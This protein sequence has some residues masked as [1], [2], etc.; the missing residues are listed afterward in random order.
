M[1]GIWTE[2]HFGVM[3]IDIDYLKLRA[4]YG[5]TASLGPATNSDVVLKSATTNR[6][7]ADERESVIQ[8]D[9]SGKL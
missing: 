7:F 3:F 4:S 5:L 8:P 9:Q 6:T 2:E 1:H